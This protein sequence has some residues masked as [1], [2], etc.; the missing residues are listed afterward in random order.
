MERLDLLLPDNNQGYGPRPLPAAR[1]REISDLVTL[2]EQA[3]L[4]NAPNSV[5]VFQH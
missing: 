5:L 4:A 2:I 3:G 1:D